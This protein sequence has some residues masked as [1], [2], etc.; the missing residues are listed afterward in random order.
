[1]ERER[2]AGSS[3]WLRGRVGR[4]RLPRMPRILVQLATDGEK[5]GTGMGAPRDIGMAT[6]A[7]TGLAGKLAPGVGAKPRLS[8]MASWAGLATRKGFFLFHSLF[9]Y[10]L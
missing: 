2:G 4:N 5:R 9:I 3:S 1:M 8:A 6:S 7:P 10:F